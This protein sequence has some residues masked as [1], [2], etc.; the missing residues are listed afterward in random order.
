MVR[1]NLVQ[2]LP[3]LVLIICAYG[4]RP[5]RV[6]LSPDGKTVVKTTG[7]RVEM[8]DGVHQKPVFNRSMAGADF[9]R[10][11]PDGSMVAVERT[12]PETKSSKKRAK[13]PQSNE[14]AV[15]SKGGRSLFSVPGIGGPFAWRPDQTEVVG[16]DGVN[17]AVMYLPAKSI[18]R[19]YRIPAKPE[20]ALWL[21]NSRDIAFASTD[22]I[23]VVHNGL[24]KQIPTDATPDGM[25]YD[26]NAGRLI[27]VESSLIE[28]RSGIARLAFSVRS[29]SPPYD[30]V[31]TILDRS[32][33]IA[34]P[35]SSGRI[36]LWQTFA[37]S[38]DGSTLAV[39]R[40][41]DA[42]SPGLMQRYRALSYRL[43]ELNLAAKS[44]QY[45]LAESV[46]A[47]EIQRK[48]KILER[49]LWVRASVSTTP[50]AQG[51]D[52]QAHTYVGDKMPYFAAAFLPISES[53]FWIDR[54]KRLAIIYNDK[55][56]T[57]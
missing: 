26:Q 11:S 57:F 51:K 2:V 1:L 20:E 34:N 47:Q 9:P 28:Q 16:F 45:S 17:A 21:G 43:S 25:A 44:R 4:C 41:V 49:N 12:S 30:R 54:G 27:W 40:I 52:V 33:G 6:D 10:F 36:T 48:M 3:G 15:L 8:Y 42:G 22:F 14:C 18:V 29:S 31:T 53:P 7:E 37:V 32:G 46:E 13:Q 39:E 5:D 35:D 38:P 19:R 23:G 55:V 24:W 56:Q 50:L